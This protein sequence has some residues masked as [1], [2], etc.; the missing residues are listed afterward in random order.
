M[1]FNID[2]PAISK[3][4]ITFAWS[5]GK[6]WTVI[7]PSYVALTLIPR[8][9]LWIMF[10]MVTS[11]EWA[12]ESKLGVS[13]H[14]KVDERILK[15]WGGLMRVNHYANPYGLN[16]EQRCNF[17][18]VNGKEE[19]LP[20]NYLEFTKQLKVEQPWAPDA[21]PQFPAMCM[22]G[23]GKD[24]LCQIGML[25]E[26]RPNALLAVTVEHR[27]TFSHPS[28]YNLLW[29]KCQRLT[30]FN[31]LPVL[32]KTNAN[33]VFDL[34]IM[35]WYIYALPFM[36]LHRTKTCY[37]AMELEFN[38][39]QNGVPVKPNTSVP[40]LL[41]INKLLKSLGYDMEF[42]SGTVP[43]SSYGVQKLLVERYPE[44]Q[45]LQTSCHHGDPCNTCPKCQC[46]MAYL[47]VMGRNPKNYGYNGK[48]KKVFE[49]DGLL[50]IERESQHWALGK[51]LD[52][53]EPPTT[54][55]VKDY[56]LN[57][58]PYSI[59]DSERILREH[60]NPWSNMGFTTYGKYTY[61]TEDWE[62]TAKEICNG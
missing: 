34:H 16:K 10:G 15:W 24:A 50:D 18:F 11:E 32:I 28:Y 5:G 2:R 58:L 8:D 57:A 12:W 27:W 38:K 25:T 9:L 23:M 62:E 31:A 30:E 59:P 20:T 42:R 46:H 54:S 29:E 17:T 53:S 48:I 39:Y 60:F 41:S 26:L 49:V 3:N 37:H 22:N 1:I 51:A 36:Y 21:H 4:S 61:D 55:W 40:A 56:W 52:G 43:L 35:P 44:L 13:L 6:Q 47:K 14:E 45:A 33:E 19:P 7:Y